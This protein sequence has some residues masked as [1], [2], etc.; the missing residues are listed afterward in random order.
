MEANTITPKPQEGFFDSNGVSIRYIEQGQGPAVVL[1]HGGFRYA[2]RWI[3]YGFFGGLLDGYRLIAVDQR[4]HGKSGKPHSP[5]AYGV[6]MV[7]DVVRLLDHLGIDKA[8]LVGHSMGAEIALKAASLYPGRIHSAVLAGSGWSD[9]SVYELIG[10]LAGSLEGG[11]GVRALVEW[12]APPGQPPTDEEVQEMDKLLLTGNDVQA[13]AAVFRSYI[14]PG[15]LRLTEEEV[16][17]IRVPILGV[18]GEHDPEKVMLE[19]MSG[20]APHFTMKVL[21]GFGHSGPEFFQALAERASAFLR[22]ISAW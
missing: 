3:D 18:A 6:E 1:L 21:P 11:Q 19:R 14:D 5:S 7:H 17:A 16:R 12:W 2:E 22:S 9:D 20:V 15:G 10:L 13:L 8:H 4:G